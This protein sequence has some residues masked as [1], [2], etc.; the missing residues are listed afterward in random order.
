MQPSY[1]RGR[2]FYSGTG[3]PN[4]SYGEEYESSM[5]VNDAKNKYFESMLNRKL[6]QAAKE[7]FENAPS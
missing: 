6:Y 3:R 1:P 5:G 2:G 7:V 4:F